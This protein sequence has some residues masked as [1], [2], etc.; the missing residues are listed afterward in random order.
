MSQAEIVSSLKG[1]SSQEM[2]NIEANFNV[3]PWDILPEI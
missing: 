2:S 3:L 1:K